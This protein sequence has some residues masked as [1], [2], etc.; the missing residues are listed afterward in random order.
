MDGLRYIEFRPYR[1]NFTQPLAKRKRQA[2]TNSSAATVRPRKAS[3]RHAPCAH[4]GPASGAKF[5]RPWMY[6]HRRYEDPAVTK[7]IVDNN[8]AGDRKMEYLIPLGIVVLWFVLQ[9]WILP[10]LGVN[11]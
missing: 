6:T 2:R 8:T 9:I 3:M 11:T 10:R 5:G 1:P 7:P 4:Y